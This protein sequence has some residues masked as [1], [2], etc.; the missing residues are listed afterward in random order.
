MHRR[1]LEEFEEDCDYK[2]E[3][4]GTLDQRGQDDA[5]GLNRRGSLG[6]TGDT[7]RDPVTDLADA[8]SGTDHGEADADSGTEQVESTGGSSRFLNDGEHSVEH[9]RFL[10]SLSSLSTGEVQR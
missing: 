6:L 8:D 5:G 10:G 2:T 9:F 3:Q 1:D 4:G 7:L